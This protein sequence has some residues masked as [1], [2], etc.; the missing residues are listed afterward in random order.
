[1]FRGPIIQ[2][3]AAVLNQPEDLGGDDG[4]ARAVCGGP[5]ARRQGVAVRGPGG[6]GPAPAV[7]DDDRGRDALE[8]ALLDDPIELRLEPLGRRLRQGRLGE[9]GEL[10]ERVGARAPPLGGVFWVVDTF[11]TSTS[12]V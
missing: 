9:L 5:G 6:P 12:S 3:Q 10:P 2:A 1:M 8:L 4:L 7:R 11:Q